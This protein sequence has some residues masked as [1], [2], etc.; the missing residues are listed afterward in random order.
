MTTAAPGLYTPAFRAHA[1][2]CTPPSPGPSFPLTGVSPAPR[3]SLQLLTPLVES[4]L[5]ADMKRFA[6]YAVQEQRAR[7]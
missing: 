3:A 5:Q 1:R 7:S 6:V 2:P 4:I